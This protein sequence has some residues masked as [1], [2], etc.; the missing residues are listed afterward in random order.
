MRTA[1]ISLGCGLLAALIIA[2]LS[3]LIDR[4]FSQKA[5]G[6]LGLGLII[7]TVI[8]SGALVSGDRQRANDFTE[9]RADKKWKNNFAGAC[10]L[11]AVPLLLL[12]GYYNYF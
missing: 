11:A 5:A 10:F 3:F 4:D 8:I 6:Y 9:S 7:I 12:W 2:A 1:K